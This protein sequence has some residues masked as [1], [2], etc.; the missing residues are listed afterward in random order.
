MSAMLRS[1][2]EISPI[3]LASASS[4]VWRGVSSSV[5]VLPSAS[6]L[7]FLGLDQ[8]ADGEHADVAEQRVGYC[9]CAPVRGVA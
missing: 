6:F 4:S 2:S 8:L 7:P 9:S 5:A 3:E 1:A